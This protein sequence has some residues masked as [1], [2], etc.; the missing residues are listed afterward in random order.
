MEKEKEKETKQTVNLKNLELRI[1]EF[2]VPLGDYLKEESLQK[3][4]TSLNSL[5]ELLVESA[6]THTTALDELYAKLKPVDDILIGLAKLYEQMM[7]NDVKIGLIA[8]VRAF[9]KKSEEEILTSIVKGK[10][11]IS[12][13]SAKAPVK[14]K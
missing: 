9:T 6:K 13:K 7:S 11:K 14:K 12:D 2:S 3:L 4:F 8:L 10:H 1:S 5:Y